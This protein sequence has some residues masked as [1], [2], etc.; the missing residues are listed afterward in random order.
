MRTMAQMLAPGRL[1]T[2]LAVDLERFLTACLRSRTAQA[3]EN[4]LLQKQLV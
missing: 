3:A 4:L 2:G 1:M